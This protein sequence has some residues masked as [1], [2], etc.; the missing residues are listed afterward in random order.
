MCLGGRA[1]GFDQTIYT[2][3]KRV[4]AAV[5][6]MFHKKNLKKRASI[7]YSGKKD[8]LVNLRESIRSDADKGGNSEG[9]RAMPATMSLAGREILHS[10]KTVSGDYRRGNV[11]VHQK[12]RGKN[13]NQR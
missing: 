3:E 9:R 6:Q 5:F 10:W 1:L 13:S 4:K 12:G 8:S 7:S 2:K 11:H